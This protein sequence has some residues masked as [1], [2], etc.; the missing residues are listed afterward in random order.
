MPNE[1]KLTYRGVWKRW[2]KERTDETGDVFVSDPKL[3]AINNA[4]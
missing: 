3:I 2:K 4:H 1:K